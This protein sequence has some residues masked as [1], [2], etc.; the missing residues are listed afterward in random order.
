[1]TFGDLELNLSRGPGDRVCVCVCVCASMSFQFENPFN[2]SLQSL[3]IERHQQ[4]AKRNTE[5]RHKSE[6]LMLPGEF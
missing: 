1:M 5:D 6:T 2:G 3:L 4:V